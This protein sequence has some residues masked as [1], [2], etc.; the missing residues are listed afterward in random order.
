VTYPN[1]APNGA[2]VSSLIKGLTRWID[3]SIFAI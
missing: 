3:W 1:Q 2:I